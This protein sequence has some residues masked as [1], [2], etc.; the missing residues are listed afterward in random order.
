MAPH[1]VYQGFRKA[2]YTEWR[3]PDAWVV[4]KDFIFP[5]VVPT[6]I[7]VVGPA[8]AVH[9]L[10]E[11]FPFMKHELFAFRYAYP[12]LFACAA[13]FVAADNV[14]RDIRKWLQGVRD[15]EFLVEM[16]L[17]NL[18]D[19]LVEDPHPPLPPQ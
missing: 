8:V 5:V 12:S 11:Q 19:Q 10:R 7:M 4:T 1:G 16:R 9:Y 2:L 17:I 3:D 13:I 6:A 14:Y 18:G 15:A